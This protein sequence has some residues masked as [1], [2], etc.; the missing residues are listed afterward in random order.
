M[1][2]SRL[3][4]QNIACVIAALLCGSCDDAQQRDGA[5]APVVDA[6]SP[7]DL[8]RIVER[9]VPTLE[10]ISGLDRREALRVRWQP[11]EEARRYVATR[12]EHELPPAELES[13]RR[14]YVALGLLPDTLDLHA[15]LLDL[16]TEQVLGYYAPTE[17]TLFIVEGAEA[18]EVQVIAHEL[19][20]AL[21][22]QHTNLDSLVAPDRGNDRQTAAH[23]ALEGHA[24]L[25]MITLLAERAAGRQ[26]DPVSLAPPALDQE[27]AMA[28]QEAEFPVF[29][30]APRIVR[31][32][33]LFPYI[34]GAAFVH[35]LWTSRAPLPRYPAPLD[36]LMPQSTEQVIAPGEHFIRERDEP[37]PVTLGS[38]PAGWRMLRED[39]LGQL[40]MSI[41]LAHHV[42]DAARAATVGWEGDRYALLEAPGNHDVLYWVSLWETAADADRFADAVR[43][44]AGRRPARSVSVLRAERDG[45]AAVQVIDAPAGVD[46]TPLQTR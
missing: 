35:A 46:V 43:S 26:V 2:S 10:R 37:V 19:V 16:Y 24:M 8:A 29:R 17:R 34:E 33:L 30:R 45:R 12:L 31:E 44:A 4:L 5:A 1:I 38:A 42:D 36:S 13:L 18:D 25:V 15:L 7:R 11:R 9:L 22:D 6:D 23:A 14:T 20:H 21:Q 28:A 32:T 3:R 41:F 40:E 27:E 39:G